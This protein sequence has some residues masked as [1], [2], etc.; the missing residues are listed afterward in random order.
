MFNRLLARSSVFRAWRPSERHSSGARQRVLQ[1]LDRTAVLA[2]E[3]GIFALAH[4]VER[5][6]QVAHDVELVEQDRRLR[7]SRLRNGAERPPHVHHG[8]PDFAALL[9][10]QP[11][12]ERRHA[13][14]GAIRAAE[15]DRPLANEV[16]DHDAVAVAFPDR[17]LVDADARGA[18]VPARL[19]WRRMYCCSSVLTVSQSSLRSRA[20]SWIDACWQRGRHSTQS[21][22]GMRVVRQKIQALAFDA[23]TTPAVDAPHLQFQD[24]PKPRTAGR[25]P[26]GS[27]GLPALLRQPTAPANCFFER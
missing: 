26:A 22:G 8:E 1:A 27:A 5:L 13:G 21:A 11:V 19:S 24:N 9:A 17:D 4:G 20:T 18:A 25:E 14:L 6:A 10:P 12:I 23:A 2:G 16:A 3:P 7:Y 15:P